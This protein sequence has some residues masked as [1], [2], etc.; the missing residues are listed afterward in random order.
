MSGQKKSERDIRIQKV[1]QYQAEF[2][3]TYPSNSE[4]TH[5]IKDV[6]SQFDRLENSNIVICGRIRYWRDH[7]KL[8]FAH[9]EDMSGKIQIALSAEEL[10]DTE[11][12]ALKLYDV[13]DIVQVTGTVFITNKGEQ[14]LLVKAIA[15]LS[16]AIQP[17]P[18]KWHG[19]QDEEMRYRKRYLDMLMTPELRD[20]FVKKAKFWNS[21]R[22]FLMEEQFIEV[23]TPVLES[24]PGGADAEPFTTHHNALDIDLYLRISMGELWQK[25]LMVSGFEKTFEIG[26]QFRNEGISPEH[27]QD[28]S[29]MEFYWAYANY[30]DGMKLV[31]SMYKHCI[32]ETFGTLKFTIRNFKIDLSGAWEIIDYRTAVLEKTGIDIKTASRNEILEKC[33]EL[34]LDVADNVTE[35]RLI[36]YLWK[37]CRKNI[38][39]PA[40][41]INHPVAV[42][43]LAKR[44]EGNPEFVERFQVILAGSE[45]GNGYSELND[46][47]DQ[48]KR[49][50][51]QSKMRESGDLEA[52]M[53]DKDFV[54]ALEYGMP[55]T[56]GFGLSERL[57]SF[58]MDKPIRECVMFPLLRPKTESSST[59]HIITDKLKV[60]KIDGADPTLTDMTA[61]ISR[62]NAK[63]LMYHNIKDENLRRH[64]L[65]TEA[66]MQRLALH[67]GAKAIE[68][69]GI[70]G[71]LHDIDWEKT[72]PAQ[73]SLV[74]ADMLEKEN[75]HPEIVNAVRE[76][77]E[78]HGLPAKTLLSR[79]LQCLEQLTGLIVA[80]TLVRPDKDI[81]KVEVKSVRKKFKDKSFAKG[82]DRTNIARCEEVLGLTLDDAIGLCLEAM[83]TNADEIGLNGE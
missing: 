47:L 49:F 32:M 71:L 2:G 69:W 12:R 72:E 14:S 5:Y 19:I 61:N 17:L 22:Q 73:H 63:A 51:E 64:M 66:L 41:L 43:P 40:M 62:E 23:E 25:R 21:I 42:S 1:D 38:G 11:Y 60:G 77:N 37:Y 52:Q 35:G 29:Q 83:Q 7:G 55:P 56:C 80:V 13:G 45:L 76:H 46:P 6:V 4:R 75:I 57:F 58:L 34:K 79:N 28:Y 39:G 18:D 27:L 81:R 3:S 15:L 65:A 82:V 54:E 31:E 53:H 16:K 44:I 30:R 67:F 10:S 68:A 48:G 8:T 50:E 36:D 24:T 9:V 26:R 78:L 59:A 33:T 74:G 20:M 70:A